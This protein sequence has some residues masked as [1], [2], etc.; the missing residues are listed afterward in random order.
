MITMSRERERERESPRNPT[1]DEVVEAGGFRPL[2]RI[3][4]ERLA[5]DGCFE[6]E[7]LELLFGV[8]VPMAPIDRDHVESTHAVGWHLHDEL[9]DRAKVY[10]QSPFAASDISEPQP[11]VLV[12][13]IDRER[14]E[15]PHHAYL[16]V[17]VSRSSLRR[18]RGMKARLYGLAQ[19]DEYWIVDQVHE[20]IEVYR[21]ARDGRWTSERT[22]GRGATIAMLAFPDVEIAVDD[23][24]PPPRS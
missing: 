22:Y 8:V 12:V 13:P 6:D 20:V 21:D 5:A 14:R 23:V 11:D 17:E 24:L 1:F 10:M 19:V 16:I 2:K 3:E 18:D 7:R 4:Y 9:R 15:H